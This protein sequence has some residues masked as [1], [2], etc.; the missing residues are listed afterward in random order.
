MSKRQ[1]DI[2]CMG[3]DI[4]IT[5]ASDIGN[6]DKDI[7]VAEAKRYWSQKLRDTARVGRDIVRRSRNICCV[8][9][10]NRYCS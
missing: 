5:E 4:F 1:R 10:A 7:L 6:R 8:A 3:K 2:A 9:E